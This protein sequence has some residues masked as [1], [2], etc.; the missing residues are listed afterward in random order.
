M[1]GHLQVFHPQKRL[2]AFESGSTSSTTCLIFLGGLTDGLLAVPYISALHEECV[3]HKISLVQCI[4]SS[5]HLGYGLSSL[6]QDVDEIECLIRH[7]RLQTGKQKVFLLGHSTG[8]QDCVLYASTAHFHG[9]ESRI[10]GCLLQGPVSDRQW[11]EEQPNYEHHVQLAR[12]LVNSG[13]AQEL[14]PRATDTAPITAERYLSLA[15][16]G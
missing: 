11:L 12:K 5:S 3:R 7:L 16:K 6:R 13:C 4:L 14:M 8:S 1:K 9:D 2:V 15:S 10:T